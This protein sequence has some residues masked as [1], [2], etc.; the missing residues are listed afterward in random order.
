[1]L[2]GD[3]GTANDG[4]DGDSGPNNLQNFSVLDS[5]LFG[6]GI[7]TVNGTIDTPDPEKVTLEFFANKEADLSGHGEGKE[8]LGSTKPG[9]DGKFG[10]TL[11][12]PKAGDFISATATDKDGNT[13]EF[14]ETIEMERVPCDLAVDTTFHDFGE[15]NTVSFADK[16]FT[17]S[18]SAD[19]GAN[20]VGTITIAGDPKFSLVCLDDGD[21]C[22]TFDIPPGKTHKFVVRFDC[23]EEEPVDPDATVTISSNDPDG[24]I[25]VEVTGTC[26]APP[27]IAASRTQL[28][29]GVTTVDSVVKLTSKI[30]NIGESDLVITRVYVSGDDEDQFSLLSFEVPDT[31]DPGDDEEITVCF[32]P[33]SSGDKSARVKVES[34]DPD[35]NPFI[36]K[37]RGTGVIGP[38]ITV[39]PTSGLITTE[40]GGIATFE[41]ATK[42]AATADVIVPLASS[43]TT[44]GAVPDSVVLLAGSIDTVT[45][46]VTG[47]DDP[48]IDGDIA[49]LILTGDPTSA[50]TVYDAFDA[51]EVAD[52]SVTNEDDDGIP[53]DLS[54]GPLTHDFGD[55]PADTLA[56][57]KFIL[58]NSPLST[59]NCVGTITIEGDSKFSIVCDDTSSYNGTHDCTSFD[60]APGDT[61]TFVVRFD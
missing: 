39:T 45:V 11:P 21:D 35:E 33:T 48:E 19:A 43:D 10:A 28:K 26:V 52:V 31:L 46:T 29:F 1:E 18:N 24:D 56:E 49:Y 55:V 41:I 15:V 23:R 9:T 17:L 54:V 60:I 59:F 42:T 25:I 37:L 57:K 36:I 58:S 40:E 53:C 22:T 30:K 2:A 5:A 12:E 6:G 13:S 44:E 61:H 3:G 32:A 20:C 47:L 51:D 4:G 14:S 38:G 34:N 7:L 27:D 16:V 50:D 8:F